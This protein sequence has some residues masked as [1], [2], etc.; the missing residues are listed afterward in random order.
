MVILISLNQWFVN[1]AQF[2]LLKLT[3]GSERKS[4]QHKTMKCVSQLYLGAYTFI[5][6]PA[7]QRSRKRAAFA[8]PSKSTDGAALFSG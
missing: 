5:T 7:T 1:I 8:A 4:K 2:C 3:G 6:D